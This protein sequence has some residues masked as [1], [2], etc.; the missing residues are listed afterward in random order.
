MI[1][2]DLIDLAAFGTGF[3]SNPDLVARL[4]NGWPLA[5]A[6]PDTFYGGGA[7]GYIDYTPYTAN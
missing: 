6:D 4:Q 1:D 5:P 7:E 2:G 3:I